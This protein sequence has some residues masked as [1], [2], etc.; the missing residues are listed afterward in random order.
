MSRHLPELDQTSLVLVGSFNPRIFQPSW[1]VRH[2]LLAESEE[3]AANVQVISNDVT[4]FETD[5]FHLEVFNDRL[6]LGSMATP[7]PEA[8]RDLLAGTLKLLRHTP[9]ERVGMNTHT[10][11]Q[12]SSEEDWHAFGH[13]LAPKTDLWE[14][15][16]RSPGT[17]TVSIQSSRSDEKYEGYVTVK[18]EPSYKVPFGIFIEVNDDYRMSGPEDTDWVVEILSERWDESRARSAQVQDHLV[19][20]AYRGASHGDEDR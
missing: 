7:V 12:L 17:R 13:R 8:M 10:H 4:V 6:H 15:I 5:W 16:M 20:L 9:V 2:G 11:Y 18:V 14:P 19:Q 1:F 3:E